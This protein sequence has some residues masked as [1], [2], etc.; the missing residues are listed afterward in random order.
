[1]R[2]IPTYPAVVLLL[3]ASA[4]V[5]GLVFGAADALSAPTLVAELIGVSY[6]AAGL[7]A[8]LG[9]GTSVRIGDARQIGPI[10]SAAVAYIFGSLC[11]Y[12]RHFRPLEAIFLGVVALTYLA[13]G[14]ALARVHPWKSAAGTPTWLGTVRFSSAAAAVVLSALQLW[15]TSVYLPANAE[16]GITLGA[17]EVR[18]IRVSKHLD[19]VPVTVMLENRST[20][21][22]VILNSMVVIRAVTY[23]PTRQIWRSPGEVLTSERAIGE[24]GGIGGLRS[25]QANIV[26]LRRARGFA[27]PLLAI[28]RLTGDGRTLFPNV[29]LTTRLVLAVKPEVRAIE[30]HAYLDYARQARLQLAGSNAAKGN[31]G[32][33]IKQYD[34]NASGKGPEGPHPCYERVVAVRTVQSSLVE[35]VTRGSQVL[36]TNWC[37][38]PYFERTWARVVG[39]PGALTPDWAKKLGSPQ[40]PGTYGIVHTQ[41]V[42]TVALG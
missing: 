24:S 18:S 12:A 23:P 38:E 31:G 36:V 41:Q 5:V 9:V 28:G 17:S 11:L 20:V 35:L 32:P 34:F 42:W 4:G 13:A 2:R 19:L 3:I 29:P 21:S 33:P 25:E 30:I 7:V 27:E 26:A 10:A 15:Y 22:A 14:V 40:T 37:F 16:V 6:V 39:R 1:M 8:L